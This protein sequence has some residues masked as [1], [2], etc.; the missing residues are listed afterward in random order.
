MQES[1]R[2][3]ILFHN[4][5]CWPGISYKWIISYKMSRTL[6]TYIWEISFI[7]NIAGIHF[8][9]II[10]KFGCNI[11]MCSELSALM[12]SWR[13]LFLEHCK[14]FFVSIC[15]SFNIHIS[16]HPYKIWCH[17]STVS[18]RITTIIIIMIIII[19]NKPLMIKTT[20]IITLNDYWKLSLVS[21]H[22]PVYKTKESLH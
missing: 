1:K 5:E 22:L 4:W 10:P 11:R 8:C 17:S 12:V 16:D 18:T 15:A 14:F 20:V 9:I 2:K 3:D 19:I 7:F 13:I 6:N 21:M